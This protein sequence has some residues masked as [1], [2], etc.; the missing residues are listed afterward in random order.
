[1]PAHILEIHVDAIRYGSTQLRCKIGGAMVQ[2]H[3]HAQCFQVRTLG[4]AT[5]DGDHP[6]TLQ[7]GQLRH[8][9]TDRSAGSSHHQGL[10]GLQ[11]ADFDQAGVRGEPRHAVHAQ[12]RAQRQS[13]R[14]QAPADRIA[15]H[16]GM[17]LPT[18]RG[19]H[20]VAHRQARRLRLQHFGHGLALHH[21]IH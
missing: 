1:M 15:C 2:R 3:V 4:L 14:I 7:L 11:L 20:Q 12:C 5:G 9:G 19:Q 21:R 10:T 16:H 13:G 17:G 18:T 8:G 6:R